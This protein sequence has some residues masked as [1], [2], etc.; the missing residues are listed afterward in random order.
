MYQWLLIKFMKKSEKLDK[1]IA[2]I[3][4]AFTS[5]TVLSGWMEGVARADDDNT[6]QFYQ[7]VKI[8]EIIDRINKLI[9]KLN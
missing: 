4:Y 7:D 1:I 9:L 5:E 6:Y 8:Q 3:L 2:D